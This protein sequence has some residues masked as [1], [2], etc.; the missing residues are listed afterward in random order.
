MGQKM[1]IAKPPGHVDWV[2]DENPTKAQEPIPAKKALGFVADERPSPLF[3]N[4]LWARIGNWQKYF[5]SATDELIT[6]VAGITAGLTTQ[7]S[8]QEVP[9]GDVDGVNDEFVLSENPADSESL[10]VFVDGI[11]RPQSEWSRV[12]QTFTFTAGNIP[13][14][15]QTVYVFYVI[16]VAVGGGGPGGG[17]FGTPYTRYL[18]LD[19]TDI[20]NKYVA[21]PDVP[22]DP[23]Q[24]VVDLVQTG[25][26]AYTDDYIVVGNLVNWNGLGL[27]SLLI[28]GDK[29]RVQYFA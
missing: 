14:I 11:L 5:E 6:D 4:W 3:H 20:T 25:A 29:L 10:L 13:Q 12:G 15:G 28:A 21:L 22:L 19:S 16:D 18:T 8:V 26:Q 1:P 7:N 17:S 24:V 9:A 2:P 27:E 23:T